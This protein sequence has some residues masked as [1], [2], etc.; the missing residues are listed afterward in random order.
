MERMHTGGLH[1]GRW[2]AAALLGG[3][4]VLLFYLPLLAG[5]DVI[6]WPTTLAAGVVLA[7][8]VLLLM[9]DARRRTFA[10]IAGLALPTFV[11]AVV[12]HNVEYAITGVEEPTFILIAIVGAPTMFLGGVGGLLWVTIRDRRM[13][14]PRS[15]TT[16][17]AA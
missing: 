10:W 2:T 7:A 13:Q 12:L 3:T 8:T 6:A 11:L 4:A 1:W 17:R 15:G 9:Q 5:R 14:R 16:T